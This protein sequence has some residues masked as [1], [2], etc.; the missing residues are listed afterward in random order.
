MTRV[1]RWFLIALIPGLFLAVAYFPL[2]VPPYLDFQVVYHAGMGLLRGI[3]LY[4]HAGQVQM[5][6]DLAG[7]TPGQVILH[8][9]PYP[10]WNALALLPLALLPIQVA[11]RLW[12]ELNILMLML[13]T[14][15]LTEGWKPW[16]RLISFPL[17][18][19]FLPV[20]GAL[21]VGQ[22]VF[23]V[24]LGMAL[25]MYS[26]RHQ[27]PLLTALAFA[28]LTFKPHLGA[29]I[30]LAGS[31]YLWQRRDAFGRRAIR[32]II[33][34]G[35][36][37]FGIGFLADPLWPLNYLQ[38]LSQYRSIET[39]TSCDICA[40]APVMV[41]DLV[42]FGGT[43]LP[44]WIAGALFLVLVWLLYRSGQT[45]AHSPDWLVPASALVTLLA[46]PYLL[47]YDFIL[48]LIPLFFIAGPAC[49]WREWSS[50]GAAYL[51]PWL[52]LGLFGRQGNLTLILSALFLAI[53]LY[54]QMGKHKL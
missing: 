16:K 17:A 35:A 23:P 6:A 53:G 4:D 54:R 41:S 10:P 1:L 49:T 33:I 43:Q 36:F 3:P 5:I 13:S 30:L 15:L 34:T 8:P 40:S 21:F 52:G 27:K 20:L 42:G 44:F 28:L 31:A 29:L 38:S 7:V 25:F 19:L 24:L 39:V 18:L 50:V 45:L 51:I 46:S 37:L 26:L 32:A 9:F 11:A 22:Y 2:P 12:F 14:F 47:N 48:L